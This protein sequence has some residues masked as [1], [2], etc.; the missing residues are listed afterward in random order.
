M[1]S[2]WIVA[3]ASNRVSFLL[4]KKKKKEKKKK[5]NTIR[6]LEPRGRLPVASRYEIVGNYRRLSWERARSF[7]VFVKPTRSRFFFFFQT[8]EFAK[9]SNETRPLL[10]TFERFRC[11]DFVESASFFSVPVIVCTPTPLKVP[12]RYKSDEEPLNS[13]HVKSFD[14]PT[15]SKGRH[16]L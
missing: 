3:K 9:T 2:F 8:F 10:V 5:K 7:P 13:K 15:G 1:P 12:K 6:N 16:V 14:C 11:I 4:K